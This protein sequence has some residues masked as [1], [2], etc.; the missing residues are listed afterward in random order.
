MPKKKQPLSLE[1]LS[2]AAVG[3]FVAHIGR[4]MISPGSPISHEMP[5]QRPEYLQN[6]FQWLNELLYSSVPRS[7]FDKMATHILTSVSELIKETKD[8]Y[9]QDQPMWL[10]LN[11]MNIVVKLTEVAV[12]YHLREMNISVWPK[13]MRHVLYQTLEKMTGLETL[14]L[15]SGSGGWKTSD[16]EK[17]VIQG[18]TAMKNLVSLCLCFD[19]TD[20]II[21]IVANNCSRL[22]I[23]DVTSSRSVTDRSIPSLL[24]CQDLRQLLLYRT[25]V[26]IEGYAELLVGLKNL[27][28]LGRCDEFGT[29]L[30]HLRFSST[31]SH[32]L[33]LHIFQSRDVTTYHLNLL[34]EMCPCVRHVSIY[35]DERISDLTVLAALNDLRELKL[36]SCDFYTDHVKLLLE[37]KGQNLTWLHLEHVEE[38]DLN[39]LI[40]ISQFCPNLKKLVFYNCDFLEHTSVSMKTLSV[41]PFQYLEYI[42]CVV[43]CALVHLEFLLSSCF[44]IKYI[45]LGSST[46]IGDDTM[47]KVLAVNPMQKLEELKILYSDNLSMHTVNLLMN[48][49]DNLRVL[50]ELE[51]WQ[52]ISPAE[53][54]QFREHLKNSN[55]DLDVRPTLSY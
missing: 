53:L 5:T 20:H 26:S 21:S 42:M 49:C 44:N 24:N 25:S 31:Y 6:T 39:A 11:K 46:G 30:E 27:R 4:I 33:G 10:F 37:V 34:I 51:S 22:R 18:I 40:Y 7:L 54:Q 29:I 23:L 15:G 19:C 50:S 1:R 14:N 32:P 36:M 3:Q 17:T 16:F 8:S 52:G 38:I 2:L 9:S 35:H 41:K 47:A 45:Q 48:H 43:D 28:D 13:I 55:T 12:N